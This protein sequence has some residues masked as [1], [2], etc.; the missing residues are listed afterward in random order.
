MQE[1]TCSRCNRNTAPMPRVPFPGELG[2]KVHQQVCDVCWKEWLGAQV[3]MINEYRLS[4]VDP[5]HRAALTE[6]MKQFLQLDGAR[7]DGPEM[8]PTGTPP[9]GS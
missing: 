9:E 8:L 2:Q 6:Q 1:I 5:E 7:A 3:N 4:M